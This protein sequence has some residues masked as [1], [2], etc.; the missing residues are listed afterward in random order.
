MSRVRRCSWRGAKTSS[1][2]MPR[3]ALT[4]VPPDGATVPHSIA[5]RSALG[6]RQGIWGEEETLTLEEPADA[7]AA[8]ESGAK[9]KAELPKAGSIGDSDPAWASAL[10]VQCLQPAEIAG[11]RSS[12]PKVDDEFVCGCYRAGLSH[13]AKLNQHTHTRQQLRLR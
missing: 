2:S 3:S 9:R 7:A 4:C 5:T 12:R 8:E 1:S 11:R 13:K 10:G 6:A